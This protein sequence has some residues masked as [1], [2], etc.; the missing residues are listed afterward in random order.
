MLTTPPDRRLTPKWPTFASAI[1]AMTRPRFMR[2]TGTTSSRSA[3]SSAVANERD[4]RRK[5]EAAA[6]DARRNAAHP[7]DRYAASDHFDRLGDVVVTMQE[8]K[9]YGQLGRYRAELIPAGDDNFLV[10][11]IDRGEAAPIKF[12][13]DGGDRPLRLD[14]G[15]RIFERVP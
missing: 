9:L 11:W 13:F 14:W 3:S 10:D 12:V 2:G 8:G 15:G 7:L 4:A 6:K 1:F 5:S